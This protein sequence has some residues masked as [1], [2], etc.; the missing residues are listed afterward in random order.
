L[1]SRHLVVFVAVIL[2][3]AGA[4]AAGPDPSVRIALS[5]VPDPV[6][7]HTRGRVTI[8]AIVKNVGDTAWMSRP[9][10]QSLQLLET[11]SGATTGGTV[12]VACDFPTLNVGQEVRCPYARAWDTAIE[13]QPSYRAN[14]LFDPDI[15]LDSNKKN[16]DVN[17]KNNSAFTSYT[18]VNG[19]FH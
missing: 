6:Y 12:K 11:P 7:P 19:L 14:I 15:L 13:F 1:K 10:Q 5:V 16:D 17:P 4:F 9:G 3:A 8:T 2:C 18:A